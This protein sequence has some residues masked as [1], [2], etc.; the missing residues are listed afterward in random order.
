MDTARIEQLEAGGADRAA[1][2]LLDLV[3]RREGP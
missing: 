3:T 2:A 1:D